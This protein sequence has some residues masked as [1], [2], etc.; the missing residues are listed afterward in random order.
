MELYVTT[1]REPREQLRYAKAGKLQDVVRK[2]VRERGLRVG[3]EWMRRT[4]PLVWKKPEGEEIILSEITDDAT[5]DFAEGRWEALGV[6][7][8]VVRGLCHK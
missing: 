8:G 7:C 4:L 5:I 3:I 6:D 1:E 2:M